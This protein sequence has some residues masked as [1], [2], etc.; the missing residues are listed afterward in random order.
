MLIKGNNF[1]IQSCG[2]YYRYPIMENRSGSLVVMDINSEPFE[3]LEMSK[4]KADSVVDRIT[5]ILKNSTNPNNRL[6]DLEELIE[7]A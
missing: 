3:R 5:Y 1:I 2:V 7:N 4:E 6:I